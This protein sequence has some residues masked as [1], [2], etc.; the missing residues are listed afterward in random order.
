M[1]EVEK[2]K[3]LKE[4]ANKKGID[5][6]FYSEFNKMKRDL[7]LER[8]SKEELSKKNRVQIFQGALDK[9]IKDNGLSEKSK[10]EILVTMENDGYDLD[11]V[12]Q[13]DN[14]ERVIR[15]Y[16]FDMI[17]ENEKQKLIKKSKKKEFKEEPFNKKSGNKKTKE[18]LQKE[19]IDQ[20]MKKYAKEN[21]L[22]Y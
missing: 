4:E 20:E 17:L 22:D 9:V 13:I 16:A 6:E 14:P 3:R 8:K 21:G 1:L 18:Q 5:P 15:G 2:E 19:L 11:K 7:E 12:L 10:E